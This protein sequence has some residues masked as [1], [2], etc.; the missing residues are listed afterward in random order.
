MVGEY[1]SDLVQYLVDE[2]ISPGERLPALTELSDELELSVGKLREQL[3]VA[4]QLG[5]VSVRPRLGTRRETY[6]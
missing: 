5:F 6:D 2:G 3:E 4:R 1:N